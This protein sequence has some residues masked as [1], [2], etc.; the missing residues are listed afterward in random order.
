MTQEL[1]PR[2]SR[3]EVSR[4]S[5]P[6]AATDA[7]SGLF[8]FWRWLF[9]RYRPEKRYMRGSDSLSVAGP[10]PRDFGS[11]QHQSDFDEL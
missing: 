1:G 3:K 4:E 2:E 10:A 11:R 9:G 6:S 5:D 8:G 7:Q